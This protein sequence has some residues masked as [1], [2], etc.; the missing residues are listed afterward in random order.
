MLITAPKI[1]ER[2]KTIVSETPA[3]KKSELGQFM[4]GEPIAEFMS[5]LFLDMNG[6]NVRLVDPGA[7]IG[8]LSA[9]FVKKAVS[10]GAISIN[11]TAFEIDPDIVTHLEE[12]LNS[13]G[14]ALR[15][16][17]VKFC[18][19]VERCDFVALG[20]QMARSPT[21]SCFTH[22]ILNPPYRKINSLSLHREELR[23]AGIETVNLY[24]AFVALTLILLENGG[25]LVAITPRSF[26]N[27]TYFRPFR[28][29]ILERAALTHAHVFGSRT[30]AFKI[31]DV[32]QENIIFRLVKGATQ[33]DVIVST[34]TDSSF[35][36]VRR[37]FVPFEEVVL[38]DDNESIIHLV[39][40]EDSSARNEMARFSNTLEDLGIG[41][42]TG[43][44]VDFRLKNHLLAERQVNSA[45]LVYPLH[46]TDG[47]VLHPKVGAKKPDWIA[48]NDETR[49]WLMPSGHYTVVR[50][51]SSKEEKR[52]IVPAVFDPTKIPCE[53]VGFE[54]HLN[55]FH[56]DK[57][58]LPPKL[59]R[60]LAVWL[61]ST[62]VDEWLRRFSGHTQVNAGDLR[63]L[64]YP[65]LKTLLAWGAAIS[66][67]LPSQEQIDALV[68][69][70][71]K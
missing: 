53:R 13:I 11:V 16:T 68:S 47:F 32:L 19:S 12:T 57:K 28:K 56:K 55:V 61:G 8:S 27:G 14:S 50:R 40:N 52:R 45:P 6:R 1:E 66:S 5:G 71:N 4:T 23:K 21:A 2:R 17:S 63:A 39:P 69:G 42:S 67:S 37:R 20:S 30:E 25:E 3:S 51:L 64:R 31:D 36:D 62:L 44:V 41:V 70:K 35:I 59:A 26:C 60:G 65:S 18:S 33:G 24:S 34:S 15:H 46:F 22:A 7:G 43:P 29:F 54:N 49:K 48:V 9:S 38:I 58:G 10:D